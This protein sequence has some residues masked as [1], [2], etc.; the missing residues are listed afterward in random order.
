MKTKAT[1]RGRPQ[2]YPLTGT[3]ENSI[4]ARLKRGESVNTI[5]EAVGVHTYAV[6]RV[7]RNS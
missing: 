2:L 1:K 6:I 7:K 5:A 3:Q 4:K